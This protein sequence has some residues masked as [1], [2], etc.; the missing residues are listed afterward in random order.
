MQLQELFQSPDL[1]VGFQAQSKWDAIERI[2]KHLEQRG[3]IVPEHAPAFLEAVLAR[4]QSMSTGM[5][6]G[7][8]MPHAAVEDLDEVVAC[9]ALCAEGDELDFESTDQSRT[10]IVVLLLIP[11][12]Q[13]L[14]HIR[15]L[16]EIAR[17]MS[18]GE[19]REHLLAASDSEAAWQALAT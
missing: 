12:K 6:H 17:L 1:L 19:A 16:A 13:K 3:R 15:T 8:A 5:E 10:R 18:K 4:E 9:L 14:L 7:L 11:R 2:L